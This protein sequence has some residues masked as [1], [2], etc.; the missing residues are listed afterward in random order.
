MKRKNPR[1]IIKHRHV[2]EKT[3][4]LLGL[5]ENVSN[6]SVARFE[7]PKYVFVVDKR[8]NKK[9]I[10]EALEEIYKDLNITVTSVN[11][12]NMKPK[13]GRMLRTRRGHGRKAGLKK[14]I[15]TLDVNDTLDNV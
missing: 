12:I 13:S 3:T 4:S 1:Q 14:A 5:K 11:T 8:A 10:A 7:K 15:V 2:T 9:E 6:P